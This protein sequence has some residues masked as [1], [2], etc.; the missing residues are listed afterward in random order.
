MQMEPT[1]IVKGRKLSSGRQEYLTTPKAASAFNFRRKSRLTGRTFGPNRMF[2]EAEDAG[3]DRSQVAISSS[4]SAAR[5]KGIGQPRTDRGL[6]TSIGHTYFRL[7]DR[8]KN[9][10]ELDESSALLIEAVDERI[11]GIEEELKAARTDRA[12][13]VTEAWKRGGK[14]DIEELESAAREKVTS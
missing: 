14:V 10:R 13:L 2:A 5:D 1:Y 7:L 9:I 11:A 4:R 6:P 12:Q 3:V 8:H